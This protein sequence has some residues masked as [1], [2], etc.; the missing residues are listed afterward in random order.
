[1]PRHALPPGPE[2]REYRRTWQRENRRIRRRENLGGLPHQKTWIP[3]AVYLPFLALSNAIAGHFWPRAQTGSASY[4]V[5]HIILGPVLAGVI[6]VVLG[7]P[8]GVIIAFAWDRWRKHRA[9]DQPG[10]LRQLRYLALSVLG[11]TAPI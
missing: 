4:V 9:H 7:V 10:L 2:A 8:V 6:V 11:V 1:M 3:L 5:T